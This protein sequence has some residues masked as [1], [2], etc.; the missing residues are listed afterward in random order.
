MSI[1]TSPDFKELA[2]SFEGLAPAEDLLQRDGTRAS[3]LERTLIRAYGQNAP[4]HYQSWKEAEDLIPIDGP[5]LVVLDSVHGCRVTSD[6]HL[7]QSLGRI[8]YCDSYRRGWEEGGDGVPTVQIPSGVIAEQ[9]LHTSI[10]S[11]ARFGQSHAA[12]PIIGIPLA[13]RSG[14]SY[15]A[16]A[17]GN[18]VES[19]RD[20]EVVATDQVRPCAHFPVIATKHPTGLESALSSSENYSQA[21]YNLMQSLRESVVARKPKNRGAGNANKRARY[22]ALPPLDPQI[23]T[24][25]DRTLQELSGSSSGS[26][27]VATAQEVVACISSLVADRL[28]ARE[29]R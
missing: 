12:I 29:R 22:M 11:S 14:E 4:A 9:I 20:A 26:F 27:T 28:A 24:I 3:T 6:L 18:K 21:L 2:K 16:D 19:L 13:L 5:Q 1:T 25:T 15:L 7:V 8:D 17:E 10:R 23:K